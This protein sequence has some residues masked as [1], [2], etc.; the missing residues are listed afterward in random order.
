MDIAGAINYMLSCIGKLP[1]IILGLTYYTGGGIQRTVSRL[2]DNSPSINMTN[3]DNTVYDALSITY[4]WGLICSVVILI[5]TIVTSGLLGI[6]IGGI[7]AIWQVI[8][9]VVGFAILALIIAVGKANVTH[10]NMTLV[11]I[12]SVIYMI[13]AVVSLIQIVTSAIGLVS[14]I[15]H[16]YSIFMIISSIIS[17]VSHIVSFLGAGMVLN[18]LNGGTPVQAQQNFSQQGFGTQP[19]DY[20]NQQN[21]QNINQ[22]FGDQGQR[23]TGFGDFN[24]GFGQQQQEFQS[25]Q[26]ETQQQ[27]GQPGTTQMYQC[28]FCGKPIQFRANPCPH[29]NNLIQW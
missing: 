1:M 20:W 13:N 14:D 29:C 18:G 2:S 7:G 8:V 9:A 11:K 24:Q 25:N 10:W 3:A 15:V 21:Q 27:Y 19:N 26:F 23:Q 5:C 12:L 17:V 4:F 28:P 16:I 22:G 6:L